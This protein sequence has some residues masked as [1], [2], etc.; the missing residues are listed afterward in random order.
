[1]GLITE[2]IDNSYGRVVDPKEVLPHAVRLSGCLNISE[3]DLLIYNEQMIAARYYVSW[4]NDG[5]TPRLN[6]RY[7][8]IDRYYEIR[9]LNYQDAVRIKLMMRFEY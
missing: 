9:F 6:N 3:I 7:D 2:R 5:T 8:S 4:L 1:M